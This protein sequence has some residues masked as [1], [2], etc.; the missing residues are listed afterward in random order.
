[1][2]ASFASSESSQTLSKSIP[3][4][5][6]YHNGGFAIGLITQFVPFIRHPSPN[7]IHS[8]SGGGV[9]VGR[10]AAL[11][12]MVLPFGLNDFPNVTMP[13]RTQA[14]KSAI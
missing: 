3:P 1:M 4:Q 2:T 11:S 10:I 13:R 6:T 9:G 14:E 7:A 12:L 8:G 5:K